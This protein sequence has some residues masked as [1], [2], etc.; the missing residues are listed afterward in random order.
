MDLYEAFALTGDSI[1]AAVGG[2]GKTSLVYRLA[3]ETAGRGSFGIVTTTVKFTKPPGMPM[4]P[5][6]T[7]RPEGL[8]AA[9]REQRRAGAA[10]VLAS[11]NAERGRLL[12]FEAAAIDRLA[13]ENL[14][15]LAIEADGSAHRP[16]KA[17][18]T[19]EPV[20]PSSTTGVVVCV[21]LEVLGHELSERWVHRSGIAARLA[22]Q[23]E[24]SLVTPNTIVRVLLHPLGGRKGVPPGA[25]VHALLNNPATP[26]HEKLALHIAQRL[27]YG[28]FHRA[29]IATAHAGVVRGVVS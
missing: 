16:F 4:P 7:V 15:L 14:G 19:H 29:V 17:P 27:V 1:V 28:G 24:G 20:I 8:A 21:G 10:V 23:P 12:G 3:A 25:K 9:A 13:A 5:V 26:E 2:G 11:G 18:A 22:E 6:V